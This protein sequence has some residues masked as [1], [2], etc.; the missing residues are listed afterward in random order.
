[1]F[2]AI[3]MLI[4]LCL[5]AL[6]AAVMGLAIFPAL[7]MVRLAWLVSAPSGVI[8]QTLTTALAAGAGFFLFGLWLVVLVGM[9]SILLRLRLRAGDY[10]MGHPESLK[11]YV[12]NALF[13]CVRIVFF[14]FMKLTPLASVFLWMMG[15]RLGRNVQINSSDIADL[16]LLEIG[17]NTVIGGNA[18]VIGHVFE[19]RGLRLK[20][21]KI[22]KNCVIGLNSVIMPGVEVGDGAVVGAGVIVP[23]DTVIPPRKIYLGREFEERRHH[24]HG[25]DVAPGKPEGAAP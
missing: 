21:V 20:K 13:L 3:Q 19:R 22:G 11:W 2:V 9:L 12:S 7:L 16:S 6:G 10:P 14:D 18:T 17:D 1:M 24:A 8:V 25:D 4:T 15:A 23:K 5:Y